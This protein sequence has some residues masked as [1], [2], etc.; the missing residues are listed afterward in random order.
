VAE[1]KGKGCAAMRSILGDYFVEL[2]CAMKDHEY[3]EFQEIITP[4]EREI[5]M[6]NV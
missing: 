3:R 2:Y 4:W 1:G 6:F 5:L